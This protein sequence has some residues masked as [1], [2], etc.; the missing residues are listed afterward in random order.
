M[1]SNAAQGRRL[2][3]AAITGGKM[4]NAPESL[5]SR[6]RRE[7][8]EHRLAHL[9]KRVAKR[10]Q[11]QLTLVKPKRDGRVATSNRRRWPRTRS[12]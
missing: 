2:S 8:T 3:V 10:R 6:M 5:E 12:L 1:A 11:T 7:R 4:A 9:P